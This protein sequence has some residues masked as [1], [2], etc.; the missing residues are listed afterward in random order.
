MLLQLPWGFDEGGSKIQFPRMQLA[1]DYKQRELV[2]HSLVQ[3]S[4]DCSL[5]WGVPFL[6]S[7]FACFEDAALL[8]A[9]PDASFSELST[10]CDA[11]VSASKEIPL[12]PQPILAPS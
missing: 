11:M 5:A 7:T 8:R 6:A 9:F 4:A 12:A 2:A 10:G 1:L 3:A